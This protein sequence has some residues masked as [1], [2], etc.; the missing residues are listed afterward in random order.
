MAD[1][2]VFRLAAFRAIRTAPRVRADLSRRARRV[3]A[4]AG[5]G[6]VGV[7]TETPR[8]RARSAVVTATA[9]AEKDNARNNTLLRSLDAGR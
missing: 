9:A 2:I 8:N 4:A 5:R 6:Y 7:D 1:R 3:A